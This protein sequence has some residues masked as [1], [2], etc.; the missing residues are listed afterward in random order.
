[1]KFTLWCVGI[2]FAILAID[3]AVGHYL[4]WRAKRKELIRNAEIN[5]YCM[6]SFRGT[7]ASDRWLS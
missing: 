1:M 4:E 7:K 6:G 3:C 2:A 5:K